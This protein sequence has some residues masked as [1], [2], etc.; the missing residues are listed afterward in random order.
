MVISGTYSL[1][2]GLLDASF[3]VETPFIQIFFLHRLD[4][5][6]SFHPTLLALHHTVL[7][8]TAPSRGLKNVSHLLRDLQHT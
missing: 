7:F 2:S 8:I 1:V 6:R 5:L 3:S 4:K